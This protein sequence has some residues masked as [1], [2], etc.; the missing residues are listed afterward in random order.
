MEQN[1]FVDRLTDSEHEGRASSQG[2]YRQP[3][4]PP[5]WRLRCY[6]WSSFTAIARS[7]GPIMMTITP[8]MAAWPS[9]SIAQP[10]IGLFK[11]IRG[12]LVLDAFMAHLLA[13]YE[14]AG[15]C[16]TYVVT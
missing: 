13:V 12:R 10:V 6:G 11:R 2:G 8:K 15:L 1:R 16:Q 9:A 5:G 7:G 4:V 14:G 3:G